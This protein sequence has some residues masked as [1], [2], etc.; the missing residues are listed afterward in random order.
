MK[1][2]QPVEVAEFARAKG[3]DHEPAF[4]WWV[5]YTLRKR[6]V[7]L[8]AVKSRARKTTQKFG[9][10]IPTSVEDA[11]RIYSANG[12]NS[13]RRAVSL[14]MHN[15]GDAFEVLH[16]GQKAPPGWNKVTGHLIFDVK[17]IFS[18]KAR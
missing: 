10:E 14:E 4:A 13:C 9:I 2:S 12:N 5:P 8:S 1:K 15:I 11:E 18:R 7:I 16:E 6:E 3:M 17:M